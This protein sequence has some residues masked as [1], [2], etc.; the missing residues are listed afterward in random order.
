MLKWLLGGG[1]ISLT[2][3]AFSIHFGKV[4]V[5]INI[6]N[7][8]SARSPISTAPP[9][10]SEREPA[11]TQIP[12]LIYNKDGAVSWNPAYG[13]SPEPYNPFKE[14]ISLGQKTGFNVQAAQKLTATHLAGYKL[15]TSENADK[16]AVNC[17]NACL[18]NTE[19]T[20]FSYRL[21]D[22]FEP[23]Y[24]SKTKPTECNLFSGSVTA[25]DFPDV[26][27]GQRN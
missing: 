27:S 11:R 8:I 4:D 18:K 16:S 2:L 14:V 9:S 13:P 1:L 26:V 10:P 24:G 20:A 25:S 6:G 22:T 19:C 21:T 15:E 7:P 17:L 12:A 3:F 23:R 5:H